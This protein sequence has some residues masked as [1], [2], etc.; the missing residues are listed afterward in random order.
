MLLDHLPSSL[1]CRLVW[2]DSTAE[3]RE[4]LESLSEAEFESVCDSLGG[5]VFG[6][7]A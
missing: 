3:K 5:A 6:G 4:S 7:E 2:L 1:R